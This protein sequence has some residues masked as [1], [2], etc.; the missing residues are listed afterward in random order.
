MWEPWGPHGLH[1]PP[2]AMEPTALLGS[3]SFGDE[4]HKIHSRM[5]P[6]CFTPWGCCVPVAD[7]VAP[8]HSTVSLC[9][10]H[11][12]LPVPWTSSAPRAT[13]IICSPCH[14]HHLL[15]VPQSSRPR[16]GPVTPTGNSPAPVSIVGHLEPPVAATGADGSGRVALPA[17]RGMAK[18][19][20]E[21]RQQGFSILPETVQQQSP[22]SCSISHYQNAQFKVEKGILKAFPQAL[23]INHS[24]PH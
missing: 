19:H 20:A 1:S 5:D 7:D 9:R 11:H 6:N 14:G 3:L 13:D 18:P 8:A 15:P 21:R 22:D 16:A 4:K 24:S 10:G 23:F 12:L 2:R 17:A